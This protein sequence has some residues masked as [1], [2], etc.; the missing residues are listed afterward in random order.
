MVFYEFTV[1]MWLMEWDYFIVARFNKFFFEEG[2]F[3]EVYFYIFFNNI[4]KNSGLGS[5]WL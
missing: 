5:L 1:I 4:M 2:R 3:L